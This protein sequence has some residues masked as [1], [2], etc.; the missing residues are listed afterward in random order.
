VSR[1]ALPAAGVLARYVALARPDH[2]TKNLLLLPG[3][4][5][6]LFY[7]PE[8]AGAQTAWAVGLTVV[9][10][11]LVASSNYV[12]NEVLDAGTDSVHPYKSRRPAAAGTISRALA[13][14]EWVA[15]GAAG[16]VV[17]FLISRPV[18]LTAM[19]LWVMGVL[20]NVPPARLKDLPYVDV[21]SESAN[22][23]LRLALGWFPVLPDRL[24]PFSLVVAYWMA[25]AFLM[26]VKRFSEYRELQAYG[27]AGAYR[28][29]FARYTEQTLLVSSIF[30]AVLGAQ[31]GGMFILRYRLELV[32]VTPLV[33]ALF[34]YYVLIAFKPQSAAQHP[35]RL[36]REHVLSALLVLC[37]VSF[38]VL[39]FVRVPWLYDWFT[40]DP[41]GA[42]PLWHIGRSTR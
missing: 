16:L 36:Y 7:S 13:L 23:A 15:L 10:T 38:V 29:S 8:R 9:A 27:V 34:A 26:A 25:G 30:Y 20:Y 42:T 14:A 11:C 24:P 31:F 32:L 19:A 22:N 12:L 41:A 1:P 28:R 6:A 4:A 3:M 5:V 35:E 2:W 39:M 17:A 37:L 33:A 21:L 18:G 40:I